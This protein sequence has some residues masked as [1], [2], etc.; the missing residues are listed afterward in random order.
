MEHE[1]RPSRPTLTSGSF[2]AVLHGT[3]RGQGDPALRPQPRLGGPPPWRDTPA[4][5]LQ[6]H[7]KRER[8]AHCKPDWDVPR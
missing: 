3:I 1:Q 4:K 5:A 8:S 7:A 6:Q 2:L